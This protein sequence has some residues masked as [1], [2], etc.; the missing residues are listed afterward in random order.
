MTPFEMAGEA[1]GE[2]MHIVFLPEFS[3]DRLS[4]TVGKAWWVK[5]SEIGSRSEMSVGDYTEWFGGIS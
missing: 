3:A 4:W 5:D 2:G 1:P